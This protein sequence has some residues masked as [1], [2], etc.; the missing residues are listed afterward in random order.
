[1]EIIAKRH[2]CWLSSTASTLVSVLWGDSFQLAW[3]IFTKLLCH[4]AIS[5]SLWKCSRSDPHTAHGTTL[6]SKTQSWTLPEDQARPEI[7][8]FLIADLINKCTYHPLGMQF[9]NHEV[10]MWAPCRWTPCR[11]H[12]LQ[13]LP[14]PLKALKQIWEQN[15]YSLDKAAF[16]YS[17]VIYLPTIH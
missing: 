12:A 6:V 3:W 8:A 9:P 17:L 7:F 4:T 5:R 13:C 2:M 1:M 14:S 15:M 10:L 16:P 11:T